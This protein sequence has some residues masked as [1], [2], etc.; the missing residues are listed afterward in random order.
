MNNKVVATQ[1]PQGVA[2]IPPEWQGKMAKYAQEASATE[3]PKSSFFSTKSGVL[4]YG[5]QPIPNNT[6]EVVV[7]GAMHENTWYSKPF[8]AGTPRTP[9]CYAMSLN[10]VH[11]APHPDAPNKQAT[12]CDDCPKGKWDRSIAGK[13]VPPPCKPNRRLACLSAGAL[14]DPANVASGTVG[15]LRIPVT[16][17][18]NY[19]SHVQTCAAHGL[20]PWAVVTEVKV[21]PDARTQFQVVFRFVA[22][23]SNVTLLDALEVR[24]ALEQVNIIQPY[25]VL[26]ADQ[27]AAQ[28]AAAAAPRKF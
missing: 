13:N 4:S 25:P 3:R 10:G 11:M 26:D 5:E 20:P 18:K 14:G 28:D 22:P 6:M 23:I 1:A 27:A 2:V 16:S 15:L 7:V 12:S 24:Q 9:D 17:I 8:D 21:V 19:S